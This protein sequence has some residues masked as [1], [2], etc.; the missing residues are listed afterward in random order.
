MLRLFQICPVSPL[1]LGSVSFW[2]AI[3]VL[4][5]SLLSCSSCTFPARPWNPPFPQRLLAPLSGECSAWIW[6]LGVCA[7][8]EEEGNCCSTAHLV[9]SAPLYFFMLKF[10]SSHQNPIPPIFKPNT[11]VYSSLFPFWCVTSPLKMRKLASVILNISAYLIKFPVPTQSTIA[12]PPLRGCPSHP[13]C[14]MTSSTRPHPQLLPT[15]T[16]LGTH[17]DACPI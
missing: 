2:H 7:A 16:R 1:R 5:T 4:S 17:V 12:I 6:M 13:K 11:R 9:D 14:R 8:L 10:M 3:I 15:H